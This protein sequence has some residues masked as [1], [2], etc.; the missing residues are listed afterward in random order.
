[1]KPTNALR[2]HFVSIFLVAAWL[3]LA[4]S[5]SRAQQPAVKKAPPR[6]TAPVVSSAAE[7]KYKGIWEPVNYPD[8]VQLHSVYFVSDKVG[9]ASGKGN[10]GIIVHT[11]DGGE[12]WDI[13]LGDP[14]SNEP[15]FQHL[16]FLDQTHGWAVQSGEKLVR[17]SDGKNWEEAGS[18]PKFQS[19]ANY[20]FTSPQI[21]FEIAGP[22]NQSRIFNTR[23]GGRSWKEMF[24]CETTLQIQGLTKK[25]GCSFMDLAF[26]SPR[27]GYA[28]GGG[29]NGGFSVIAKTEDSGTTWHLIFASTD[30]DTIDAVFF[31]DESHGVIRLR[32]TKIFATEDG[33]QSWRGIPSSA[34]GDIKFGDPDVGWSCKQRTCSFTTDGGQHWSSRE[35]R[36]PASVDAFSVPRRD[37][38]FVV[39]DHGM[40][41]RYRIVPT[42]Y[43]ARDIADAPLLPAY[44]EPVITQLGRIRT[45]VRE[46]QV[47]LGVP[48][49]SANAPD[50]SSGTGSASTSGK[51]AQPGTQPR[52]QVFTSQS[53]PGVTVD[54]ARAGQ[55]AASASGFSQ[56]S[57]ASMDSQNGA[58]GASF[59]QDAGFS[60]D[61]LSAPPS[62]AIQDC[63]AAQFQSLQTDVSAF[64]QQVPGF[65]GKFRNLNLLFVG[66]NMLSD[67]TSKARGVRDSFLAF[68]KAPNLQAAAAA[69]QDMTASVENTSQAV[70]TGFQSLTASNAMPAVTGAVSNML[71]APTAGST[72]ADPNAAAPIQPAP[73][74]DQGKPAASAPPPNK[75]TT[76]DDVKKALK[77]RIPF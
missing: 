55:N 29:Y 68:K 60:Q 42:D 32:D 18:F 34:S 16:H 47:K 35:M 26:P 49:G 41:Y 7:P 71:G 28:V 1:M 13:Q 46:L 76:A 58:T 38:I 54:S 57:T 56:G 70:S 77:K 37:K 15:P 23:D 30:M 53:Q 51:A 50:S 27:I 8:D 63:C 40:V 36:L 44:G 20:V 65:T 48:A 21:G 31:T 17:T 39:G 11:T 74:A 24:A 2:S 12:H 9:W 33:G 43:T 72:S 75:N 59:V 61:T 69:L 73:S 64:S 66:M 52:N 22:F 4:V 3:M 67:L 19:L 25:M 10:G 45:R 14:K 6:A 5:G 62:S